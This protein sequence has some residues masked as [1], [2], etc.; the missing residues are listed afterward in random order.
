MADGLGMAGDIATIV[1][2]T[3]TAGQVTV[4]AVRAVRK[5][6]KTRR[7]AEA[8]L[9]ALRVAAPKIQTFKETDVRTEVA[10]AEATAEYLAE[11]DVWRRI[12]E[13]D[14]ALREARRNGTQ[15]RMGEPLGGRPDNENEWNI[16]PNPVHRAQLELI[17]LLSDPDPERLVK[18]GP[19]GLSWLIRQARPE[20]IEATL[21]EMRN[22]MENGVVLADAEEVIRVAADG[23]EHRRLVAVLDAEDSSAPNSGPETHG[24]TIWIG[25]AILAV[26]IALRAAA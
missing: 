22:E 14:G 12:V 1:G 18:K 3:I 10:R 4:S 23:S 11:S 7:D 9:A 21:D 17:S 8:E 25:P 26:G 15:F 24:H 6:R 2:G 5:R 16:Y 20:G 19:L 13:R